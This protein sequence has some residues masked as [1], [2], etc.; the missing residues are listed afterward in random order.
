MCFLDFPFHQFTFGSDFWRYFGL[1][2]CS[3]PNDLD[4]KFCYLCSVFFFSWQHINTCF[5]FVSSES[6]RLETRVF[7]ATSASSLRALPTPSN[8]DPV[9]CFYDAQNQHIFLNCKEIHF[10]CNVSVKISL[11]LKKD[12]SGSR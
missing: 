11:S 1:Q 6:I 9:Y 3:S 7:S 4:R 12:I 10:Q 5:V 8:H 2:L